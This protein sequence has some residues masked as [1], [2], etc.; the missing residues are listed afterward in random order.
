MQQVEQFSLALGYQAF[1]VAAYGYI[2][3]YLEIMDDNAVSKII[4]MTVAVIGEAAIGAILLARI[5]YYIIEV[6]YSH[7]H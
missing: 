2:S 1:P 4:T 3:K 7:I 6:K 5:L